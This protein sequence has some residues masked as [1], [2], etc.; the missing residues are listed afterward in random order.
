MIKDFKDLIVWQKAMELVAEVYGLVK[1]LPKEE[2]FALSDQIRRSAVSIPS[3]IAEGQARNSTKEFI[4]FLAI[5]K[6]SKSELETQLLLCV[7]IN[8]LNNS[9]IE[10]AIN[11]IQE[12]GKMLNALQKSLTTNN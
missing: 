2:V 11:L 4:Q 1:K 3:N 7:K 12:V 8:Y 6:G 5:A 10:I 9:D